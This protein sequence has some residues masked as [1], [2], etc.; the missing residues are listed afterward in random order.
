[1]G[2]VSTKTGS[3]QPGLSIRAPTRGLAIRRTTIGLLFT[4]TGR[5]RSWFQASLDR[6][7]YPSRFGCASPSFALSKLLGSTPACTLLFRVHG[8]QFSAAA[9]VVTVGLSQERATEHCRFECDPK[10]A[11][12]T[13]HAPSP[14]SS[15]SRAFV[16]TRPVVRGR[17]SLV[18]PTFRK[19]RSM[20]CQARSKRR[21]ATLI[22]TLWKIR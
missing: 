20:G 15:S 1:M 5:F 14:V 8:A 19:L 12:Q 6:T 7:S 21:L 22:E 4:R 9:R 13:G 3:P 18:F 10:A 11:Q 16:A 17:T 2:R